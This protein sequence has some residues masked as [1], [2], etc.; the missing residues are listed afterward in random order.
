[1]SFK[2]SGAFWTRTEDSPNWSVEYYNFYQ[3]AHKALCGHRQVPPKLYVEKRRTRIAKTTLKNENKVE[4]IT[5][6]AINAYY[7]VILIKK[8]NKAMW[9]WWRN[10]H[11]D[12]WKRIEK[13]EL[14]PYKH[15]QIFDKNVK[16]I[17]WK[18][19]ECKRPIQ[20]FP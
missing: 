15:T 18:F 2:R 5:L 12:Q 10:W 20:N 8:K 4:G 16:A 17:Q 13:A 7:M 1:M 11:T 6:P 9:Y 19:A 3:N 14:H